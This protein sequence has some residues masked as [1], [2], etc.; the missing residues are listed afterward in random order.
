MGKKVR[1]RLERSFN[2]GR[3]VFEVLLSSEENNVERVKKIMLR[4]EMT[5][6]KPFKIWEEIYPGR[7]DRMCKGQAGMNLVCPRIRKPA[8]CLECSKHV[9]GNRNTES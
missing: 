1:W 9:M 6:K 8:S 4:K 2:V 5:K 3:E 7:E